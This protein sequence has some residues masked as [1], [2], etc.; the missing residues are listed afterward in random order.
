MEAGRQL[1]PEECLILEALPYRQLLSL[2]RV[3]SYVWYSATQRGKGR[4]KSLLSYEGEFFQWLTLTCQKK[5]S[6]CL[7]LLPLLRL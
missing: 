7:Y 2:C 3:G 6:I 4:E 5:A 1:L